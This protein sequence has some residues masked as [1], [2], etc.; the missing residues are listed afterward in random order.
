MLTNGLNWFEIAVLAGGAITAII[1]LSKTRKRSTRA[2]GWFT[3][4]FG[5]Y[6]AGVFFVTANGLVSYKVMG[7]CF[8][9]AFILNI[10]SWVILLKFGI[11]KVFS[12]LRAYLLGVPIVFVGSIAEQ[13]FGAPTQIAEQYVVLITPLVV[14]LFVVWIEKMPEPSDFDR[15]EDP[16]NSMT[17]EETGTDITWMAD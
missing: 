15:Y 9:I 10:L 12:W 16:V 3:L 13:F 7:I 11:K 8:T 4:I 1:G 14:E 6:Y 2:D 5:L 17:G